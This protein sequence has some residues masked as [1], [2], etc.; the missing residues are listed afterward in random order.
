LGC[1]H[2]KKDGKNLHLGLLTVSPEEQGKGIGK[3]LLK[4]AEEEAKKSDCEYI[5]MEV[6]SVRK[7]LIEW[8]FR[9]GYMKTGAARPF[10]KNSCFGIPKLPL[11]FIE[12]EKLVE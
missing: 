6:I 9:N 8:Y 11:E 3:Q 1:V 12:L 7:E 10:E 5:Q 2:L 4:A